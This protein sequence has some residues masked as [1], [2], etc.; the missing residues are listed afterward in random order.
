MARVVRAY[1]YI[2]WPMVSCPWV[3]RQWLY[4]ARHGRL[5]ARYGA[6]GDLSCVGCRNWWPGRNGQTRNEI[7]P[8]PY[9]ILPEQPKQPTMHKHKGVDDI[10]HA[11]RE[12]E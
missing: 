11:E 4:Y 3:A 1:M 7:Q 5:N 8:V 9:Q 10:L 12:S 2:V 6:I